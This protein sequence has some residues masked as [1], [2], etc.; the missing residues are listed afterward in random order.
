MSL[1][2]R[3]NVSRNA[4]SRSAKPLVKIFCEGKNTEPGYFKALAKANK[5]LIIDIEIIPAAGSPHTIAKKAC[6]EAKKRKRSSFESNDCACS[7]FDCDEHPRIHEALDM[8]RTSG[9]F[10]GYSNPCFEIWLIQHHEEF[11]KPDD[12]HTVQRHLEKIDATYSRNRGKEPDYARLVTCVEVA[13]KNAARLRKRREDEGDP[14]GRPYTNI[15]KLTKV[16]RGE[17]DLS[18]LFSD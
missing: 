3:R 4:P 12:R 8:C 6:A 1:R 18:S 13:E 9:V 11:D 17:A 7:I 2:R 5:N 16:I 15:D 14:L 10:A